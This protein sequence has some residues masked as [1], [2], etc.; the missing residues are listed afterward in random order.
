MSPLALESLKEGQNK[1][2]EERQQEEGRVIRL[3]PAD[4]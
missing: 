1:R 2:G 4:R 3:C